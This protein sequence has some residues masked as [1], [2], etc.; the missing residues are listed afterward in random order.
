MCHED[1]FSR[2]L[3][4][5]LTFKLLSLALLLQRDVFNVILT[6]EKSCK[7]EVPT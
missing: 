7:T 3:R 2:H 1:A 6:L 5:I 4:F